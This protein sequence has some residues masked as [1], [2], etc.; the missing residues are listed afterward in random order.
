MIETFTEICTLHTDIL[1]L[2]VAYYD[3]A[4]AQISTGQ[5]R[6]SPEDC[7]GR[8]LPCWV[9]DVVVQLFFK[10]YDKVRTI[11]L[12]NHQMEIIFLPI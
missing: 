3:G 7:K 1:A 12:T 10:A 4:H 8:R 11:T 9:S 2:S 5:A 6:A